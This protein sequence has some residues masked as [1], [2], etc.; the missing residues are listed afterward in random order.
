VNRDPKFVE[1]TLKMPGNESIVTLDSVKRVLVDDRPHDFND[2]IS[3]AR[4]YFEEQYVNQIKQL[5]FNFAPDSVT[6][7]GVPFWSGP[8]RCPHPLKYDAN[9]ET[10]LD[11]V[12][13]A[14]NLKAYVYN[15]PQNRDRNAVKDFVSKITVKE[16]TPRSGI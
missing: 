1:R 15:I 8:K 2:C 16:F 10:H 3:W 14:A 13:A 11:Y 7:S 12:Y 6:N 9:N 5:L 4:V